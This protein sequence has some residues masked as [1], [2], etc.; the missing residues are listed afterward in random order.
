M[1]GVQSFRADVSFDLEVGVTFAERYQSAIGVENLFD[2]Y[3]QRD[4][5]NLF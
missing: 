2:C 1:A 4:V 5:R 3:P